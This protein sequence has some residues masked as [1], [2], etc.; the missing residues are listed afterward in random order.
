MRMLLSLFLAIPIS[1][2]T[3]S[4]FFWLSYVLFV[5]VY[6]W[7]FH[8]GDSLMYYIV[9]GDT[10]VMYQVGLWFFIVS[11][12]TFNSILDELLLVKMTQ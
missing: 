4:A 11:S 12:K 8:G 10:V 2:F 3:M 6:N 9:Q 5:N 1:V 7:L